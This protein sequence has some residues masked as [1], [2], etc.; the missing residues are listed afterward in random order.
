MIKAD[1]GVGRRGF[2]K[3]TTM[4]GMAAALP[5][6]SLFQQGVAN[7]A[8]PGPTGSKR[9]LAILSD[10]PDSYARLIESI[11]SVPGFDFVISPIKV[12]YQQPQEIMNLIRSKNADLVLMCTPRIMST[13]GPIPAAMGNLDIPIVLLPPNP[14]LIMLE[15]DMVATFRMKGTNAMLANSEAQAVDLLKIA[16]APRILEGRKAVIFGRP[17]D[18]TSVPARHLSEE[19]VYKT[20]GVRLQYRPIEELKPLLDGVSEE[21]EIGRAH[22]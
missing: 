19:Y 3:T 9:N 2:L 12:N 18:S 8:R 13:S 5:A 6:T 15:A 22:V 10:A 1:H 14:D 4:A 21:S 17:F 20:T 16:A 7:S 11:K